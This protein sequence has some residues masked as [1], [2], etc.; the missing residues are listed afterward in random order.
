MTLQSGYLADFKSSQTAPTQPSTY[1]LHQDPWPNEGAYS[2][3]NDT[4]PKAH[5]SRATVG[6]DWSKLPTSGITLCHRISIREI[7]CVVS[8]S[9]LSMVPWLAQAVG[10]VVIP[11]ADLDH[12][13]LTA[14]EPQD[15]LFIF[16]INFLNYIPSSTSFHFCSN[17][18]W[19]IYCSRFENEVPSSIAC[20]GH[21]PQSQVPS[22]ETN[23]WDEVGW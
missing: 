19:C 1:Q 9:F 22:L 12:H 8:P 2:R 23:R 16:Q 5:K 7:L 18:W 3:Q 4:Y 20:T 17:W 10:V 15:R 21:R 14:T 6:R 13:W 11:E